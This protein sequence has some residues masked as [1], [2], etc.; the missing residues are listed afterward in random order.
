MLPTVQLLY[1]LWNSD[2]VSEHLIKIYAAKQL[3]DIDSETMMAK[4]PNI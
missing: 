1:W 3:L 4:C 2:E